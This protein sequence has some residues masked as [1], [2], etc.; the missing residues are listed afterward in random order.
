MAFALAGL[1]VPGVAIAR[2]GVR[3]QIVAAV[4]RRAARSL[5]ETAQCVSSCTGAAASSARPARAGGLVIAVALRPPPMPRARPSQRLRPRPS[6]AQEQAS[7][8]AAPAAAAA[9]T[10]AG[11]WV[12]FWALPSGDADTQCYAFFDDGRFGWRAAASSSEPARA[13]GATIASSDGALVLSV[14]GQEQRSGCSGHGLPQCRSRSPR[15]R[16]S[17]SATARPTKRPRAST[18]PT[19]AARSPGHAFW[20]DSRG[21]PDP[22]RTFRSGVRIGIE[23]GSESGS[24]GR[25]HAR[26]T[27]RASAELDPHAA[28]RRGPCAPGSA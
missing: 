28:A 5:L 16:N 12:E 21:S 8:P 4:L 7:A 19:R 15:S 17:R 14:E 2:P 1:R 10:L 25:R 26:A 13:A 18:P 9:P 24:E 6:P 27:A 20:R 22:Q 11:R 23:F 3:E